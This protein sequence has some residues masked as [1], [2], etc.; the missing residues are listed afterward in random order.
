M[1]P[2]TIFMA[3]SLCYDNSDSSELTC[4]FLALW[5]TC[6]IRYH[7]LRR[8]QRDNKTYCFSKQRVLPV[9]PYLYPILPRNTLL[10]MQQ[11]ANP[12][13]KD[14]SLRTHRFRTTGA[15]SLALQARRSLICYVW[16]FFLSLMSSLE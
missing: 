4:T 13:I 14:T 12:I 9:P 11:N 2:A 5:Y 1:V 6:S 15:S 3:S 7:T 10:S 16:F 8:K